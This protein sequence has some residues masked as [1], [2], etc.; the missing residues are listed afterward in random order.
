[1]E[2]LQEEKSRNNG[3]AHHNPTKEEETL[4]LGA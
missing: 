1:M 3:D 4:Y 2:G